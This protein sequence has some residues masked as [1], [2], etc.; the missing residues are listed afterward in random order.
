[1]KRYLLACSL[2]LILMVTNVFAVQVDG[3]K[4]LNGKN[5][6]SSHGKK[7]ELILFWGTWC[8]E[9]KQKMSDIL[10]AIDARSDVAVLTVNMDSDVNRV[11]HFVEKE[12]IKLAVLQD[13]NKN[14]IKDLKVFAVPHW[15]IYELNGKWVLKDSASAFDIDRINKALK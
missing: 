3:L 4:D 11:K 13:T 7:K 2:V 1:M 14:L 8:K 6:Q 9:C 5:Y 15:A 10:P 12:G